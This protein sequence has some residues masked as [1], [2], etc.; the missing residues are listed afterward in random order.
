MS[1]EDM[2]LYSDTLKEL[3]N[4]GSGSAAT[5][6][7]KMLNRKVL[8]N[9]PKAHITSSEEEIR[10]L[11][12]GE[13]AMIIFEVTFVLDDKNESG[14]IFLFI[15]K[16]SAKTLI[17]FMLDKNF[18]CNE[19]GDMEEMEESLI[20][21]TANIVASS[22]IIPVANFLGSRVDVSPP[23]LTIDVAIAAVGSVLAQQLAKTGHYFFAQ[24]DI[25]V[26]DVSFSIDLF[27]F[28]YFDLVKKVWKKLNM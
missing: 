4:M 1:D 12:R 19:I 6:L 8:V 13:G 2:E 18:N 23:N 10:P 22:L 20:T 7:S 17:G 5:S 26:S 25:K 28:P 14:K 16:E 11:F 27:L 9:V 21:E 24:T 15:S 3:C